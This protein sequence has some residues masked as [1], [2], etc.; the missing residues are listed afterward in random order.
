MSSGSTNGAAS[1]GLDLNSE[2]FP[3]AEEDVSVVRVTESTVSVTL[4]VDENLGEQVLDDQVPSNGTNREGGT[5][6][7]GVSGEGRNLLETFA[8]GSDVCDGSMGAFG[9]RGSSEE[10]ESADVGLIKKDSERETKEL[11]DA[12]GD[13]KSGD[14]PDVA[15]TLKLG[16][17]DAEELKDRV[18]IT[19]AESSMATTELTFEEIHVASGEKAFELENTEV[20]NSKADVTEPMDLDEKPYFPD[21][22]QGV[23]VE[24]VGGST[25]PDGVRV[26][27][28]SV[29]SF[30]QGV[31]V[32]GVGGS[33][34]PDGVRDTE[35]SVSLGS[36]SNCVCNTTLCSG[37]SDVNPSQNGIQE[38]VAQIAE[39]PSNP[40]V[41]DQRMDLHLTMANADHGAAVTG[42]TTLATEAI[43][44]SKAAVQDQNQDA[45]AQIAGT[46]GYHPED[47]RMGSP[48]PELGASP[49]DN[50]S[51]GFDVETVAVGGCHKLDE[52]PSESQSQPIASDPDAIS[53]VVDFGSCP[54]TDV[55]KKVL[56]EVLNEDEQTE[57]KEIEADA[58]HPGADG[59]Q[60]T[61]HEVL[62]EDG[63]IVAKEMC[64][65]VNY[66]G[67]D[68]NQNTVDEVFEEEGS[69]VKEM[70]DDVTCRD[71][72]GNQNTADHV[73][74]EEE[75]MGVKEMAD[76][77]THVDKDAD[78][79]TADKVDCED[80]RTEVREVGDSVACLGT[81]GNLKAVD[82]VF[83]QEG[84]GVKEMLDDVTC[85]DGDGNQNTAD[86]VL[87]EDE[88]T[89]AKEMADDVTH[90]DKD[91]NMTT[92][93][94]V[95]CEDERTEVREVGDSVSCLG[96]DGNLK[97][98]DEVFEEEGNGVKE[99]LDD[100]T[101]RDRDGNQN[102]ADNV[103]KE[104]EGT[105][106]KEMADDVTHL[107]K[108]AD[109]TTADK[110]DCE[111][112]RTEVRE[113]GDGV[114]CL[115]TDG[116]LKAVDEVF[117]E[118]GSRV[119]EMLDDVTCRDG[120][121]NHKPADNV[122]KDDEGT[123]VKEM[124][125]DVTHLDK[126]A[127]MTTAEKVDCEDERTE[128]RG[129][130]DGVTCLGTGGNL[131]AVDEVFEEEGSR[132]K[133]ML[134]DVT[135]RDRDGNQNPADNVLKEDE[136]TG[137]KE[138]ADDVTH[139]DKDADMTTADKVDCEDERTEVREVGDGV[140]CLGTEGNLK[141]G[142]EIFWKD[143]G[144]EVMDGN[145][146]ILNDALREGEGT[147]AKE[148][149][150]DVTHLT[151]D[152]DQRNVGEVVKEDEGSGVKEREDD[153][154]YSVSDCLDENLT[155]NVSG[156]DPHVNE[157]IEMS[158]LVTTTLNPGTASVNDNC[159]FYG[160]PTEEGD[161]SASDLVWGK[162]KSH[163]WWPGQIF[164]PSDASEQA[165][166]YR[167]KDSFLVAYFGDRTFAW[168]EA[169]QL[170]PFRTHFSQM[171]K[172]ANLESLRKA[173]DCALDE[174]TRRVALGLACFCTS[175]EVHAKNGSQMIGNPGIRKES[176]RRE[177]VDKSFSVSS[178]EPE[179]LVEYIRTLALFP[180]GGVD[181][182]ELVIAQVQLLAVYRSRGYSC[183]PKF[184]LCGGLVENEADSLIL[185]ERKNS[186]EVVD[187]SA[188]IYKN[189]GQVLSGKV[190]LK[191]REGSFRKRKHSSDAGVHP[192][193]KERSLSELM[194]G[195]KAFSS[196]DGNESV[197]WKPV[198]SSSG[199]RK[200]GDSIPD[201]SATQNRKR[202]ISLSG[203]A[204]ADS[205]QP[206]RSFKVGESICRVASQLTGSPPIL[207]CS[208]ERLRK[209]AVKLDQNRENS[210]SDGDAVSPRTPE[211]RRKIVLP[212]EHSSPEEMLSQLCL[213]ARDPMKGY[214]FLTTIISF[215]SEFRNFVCL[216][217]TS[218]WKHKMSSEKEG[219][220][221]KKLPNSNM[222]SAESYSFEDMQDS[223]WT[224]RIVQ[225]GPEE[226]PLE[227]SRKKR[228]RPRKKTVM[229]ING[230]D[231]S[232]QSSPA[233][234]IVQ[235][236]P[237]DNA[238][239]PV[240]I[241]V[242]NVDA[243]SKDYNSPAALILSFS[244]SDA[245][246]IP[247]EKN[248]NILFRYFGPLKES[249]TEVLKTTNCARV[250]FKRHTDAE[251]A[252][253]S[254][255]KFSIFG[256][257]HVSYRLTHWPST[258]TKAS[259]FAG[260]QLI[261]YVESQ[262]IED[263]APQGREDVAPQGI[264]D[265]VPQVMED[266]ESQGMEDMD[267]A[268]LLIEDV[269]PQGMEDVESQGMEDM[270]M[271][272]LIEDVV[273]QGIEDMAPKGM[274]DV[275]SQGME[276]MESQGIEEDMAPQSMEDVELQGIED[277]APQGTE[278][279]P[280]QD[281]EDRAP[282][283]I[284]DMAAQGIEDMA[285]QGIEDRAPQLIE[286]VAPEGMEDRAPQ[287][288]EDVAPQG[289][290]GMV[291]AG[292][293][294]DTVPA[295]SIE[296]TVPAGSIEDTVPAGGIEDILPQGIEDMAPVRDNAS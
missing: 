191:S 28:H 224:D 157:M 12:V 135:C 270:D 73:L 116:N 162:V 138:M 286:D 95:D 289:V 44:E 58:T 67:E 198:S 100:V 280:P 274:E 1:E 88:G 133:E 123:G 176:S 143:E 179:M 166:K 75:G 47:R 246:S 209:G 186:K 141:A 292:S 271:A 33:T 272:P 238:E 127:D 21:E 132:V 65:K 121:G 129:V 11:I 142:D 85:R 112:E 189:E 215:F 71:G 281:I 199:K 228:G 27:D 15:L 221:K 161:F 150:D 42:D 233:L 231:N 169:S 159:V 255:G 137:V 146:M 279:V 81:D 78:M 229:L 154:I 140:A 239:Q 245:D 119:K 66:P 68:G 205:A 92:A 111:D 210:T 230:V 2:A 31:E 53:S 268:P 213:A 290:G 110:V 50:Q 103:L 80:E 211:R 40:V 262:G 178:F 185:E 177:G 167:K 3:L 164:D 26:S 284:E 134:D 125:D 269:A 136:G 295:G 52:N 188:A 171:E 64:D 201:D 34:E 57:V 251:V 252:L 14:H 200:A 194:A 256:P 24:G 160:L 106:V 208:S 118:E 247:S 84:S 232:H 8:Q 104:D 128:V 139:L 97:A 63:G 288:I 153:D 184:Q 59:S 253:S 36:I 202:S 277:M 89:G 193:K 226:Q 76:D 287:L 4:S 98:V 114:A 267:M 51:M 187:D 152:G 147:E 264:E 273:P 222:D 109:M 258:L 155:E 266:V 54:C 296:D 180:Y 240:E 62:K 117:K 61:V 212:T 275:E 37:N 254:A 19:E 25:E 260:T 56:E 234:D 126:D 70:L 13:G 165:M 7:A 29:S 74:K 278:D 124:A 45:G 91:A 195:K 102:P 107:D 168:N 145:Q 38:L 151:S 216:D 30:L 32:E 173:V 90:L 120:D 257:M 130:G 248:L 16:A 182:L 18:E 87:K 223:Y 108:D 48:S 250:V 227:K 190:K 163:P 196:D 197:D 217:R 158:E 79:T 263:V 43:D 218:S 172:Q 60:K 82:E 149:G 283:G 220:K 72:D 69:G 148:T 242:G 20:L 99:M 39:T 207:K 214:S 203:A 261:E 174:I 49:V 285:A 265:M 237:D 293:I 170:K 101:C 225:I 23:E 55:E 113:V 46:F 41:T 105:E 93:D 6:E 241:P 175:E 294:E 83:E 219:G 35:P 5:A 181:R 259:S 96:T 276:D 204:D 244:E 156:V 206:K 236:N 249:E 183:L 9:V 122:L 291:P 22:N 10:E 77:V 86:D 243:K 115:G 235:H 17:S 192:N 144:T 131:K 94:K 282:Q